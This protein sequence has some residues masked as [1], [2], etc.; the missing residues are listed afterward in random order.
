MKS[1]CSDPYDIKR[2]EHVLGES[3]MMVPDSTKRLQQALED[4]SSF[5]QGDD[6]E[7]AAALDKAGEWFKTAVHILRDNYGRNDGVVFPETSVEG[8]AEGE[9]F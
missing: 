4:L 2:F 1:S 8:L 9:A 7:I 5:I 3:Y 6:D